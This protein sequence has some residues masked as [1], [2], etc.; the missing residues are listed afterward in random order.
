MISGIGSTSY[1]PASTASAQPGKPST[2]PAP[3]TPELPSPTEPDEQAKLKAA[4]AL[5][6]N[7]IAVAAVTDNVTIDKVATNVYVSQQ[8]RSMY[9]TY[10]N[11]SEASGSDGPSA[12]NGPAPLAIAAA[13]D[14]P[15]VDEL[16][17]TVYASRQA[18]NAANNY[19]D[20]FSNTAAQQAPKVD[21][22]A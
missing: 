4:Q 9:E 2:L 8:A 3:V 10:A 19:Q 1:T 11:N 5:V 13:S 18:L 6:E 14:N 16:A 17:V 7:P 15:A 22:S 20:I 12:N 21:E